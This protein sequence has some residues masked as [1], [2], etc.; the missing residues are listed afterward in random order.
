MDMELAAHRA[1]Q[2]YEDRR[3]SGPHGGW[4]ET[5]VKIAFAIVVAA[6]L[7]FKVAHMVPPKPT[8]ILM[9]QAV[10]Q[11]THEGQDIRDHFFAKSAGWTPLEVTQARNRLIELRDISPELAPYFQ[12]L[13][14][15]IVT[16]A[17]AEHEQKMRGADPMD[18]MLGLNA[19]GA[20][21]RTLGANPPGNYAPPTG[22]SLL[23]LLWRVVKL[24]LRLYAFFIPFAFLVFFARA[25]RKGILGDEIAF[26]W[27]N[28]AVSALVWPVGLEEY[29]RNTALGIRRIRLENELRVRL[30]KTGWNDELTFAERRLLEELVQAPKRE[31]AAKL[32]AIRDVPAEALWQARAAMYASMVAGFLLTSFSARAQTAADSPPSPAASVVAQKS[33]P[34]PFAE[35]NGFFQVNTPVSADPAPALGMAWLTAKA[36]PVDGLTVVGRVDLAQPKL[37][38]AFGIVRIQDT[39]WRLRLGQF[40]LRSAFTLPLPSAERLA[41]GPGASALLSFRD[42][43]VEAGYAGD[44]VQVDFAIVT[45]AGIGTPDDNAAKDT[46]LSGA[47]GPH[48]PFAGQLVL[49]AGE[50]PQGWRFRNALQAGLDLKPVTLDAVVSHQWFQNMHSFVASLMVAWRAASHLDLA[51]GWDGLWLVGV[52][53]SHVARLQATLLAFDDRVRVGLMARYASA[54]NAFSGVLRFQASF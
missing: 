4:P 20:L 23:G 12:G 22:G 16:S 18:R 1:R 9:P 30:G 37:L 39:P 54:Q 29:P 14:H 34:P 50:Q 21:N 53:P 13:V 38:E 7:G 6:Y 42:L 48:G 19:I 26:G 25:S 11:I 10:A 52:P 33:D 40:P 44:K 2:G 41:G 49:Q 24:L 17:F 31:L 27:K 15:E 47:F 35:A 45:G 51:A 46:V 3:P 43:G 5:L 8:A 32:T 28:I 36:H